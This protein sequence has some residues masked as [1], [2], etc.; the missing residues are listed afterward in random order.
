MVLQTVVNV[1]NLYLSIYSRYA[2]RFLL[3]IL[4]PLHYFVLSDGHPFLESSGSSDP[5]PRCTWSHGHAGPSD[6]R[7]KLSMVSR[8]YRRGAVPRL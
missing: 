1:S 6:G 7:D 8:V 5:V 3:E 2:V 4:M